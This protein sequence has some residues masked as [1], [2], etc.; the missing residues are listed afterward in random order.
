MAYWEEVP[1]ASSYNVILFINDQILS[2]KILDR[3]EFYYTFTGLAA[4][5]NTTRGL[6]STLANSVRP[7]G[8]GGYYSPTPS[9]KNYYVQVEA[10]SRDGKV[11]KTSAKTMCT[12]KEL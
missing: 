5:D 11:L 12:V 1:E 7:I 2:K 9:G 8:G 10:E 6:L 3:N 4:I